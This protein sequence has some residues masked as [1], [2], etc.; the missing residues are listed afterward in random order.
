MVSEQG[1]PP[2]RLRERLQAVEP[3]LY[4]KGVRGTTPN[5]YDAIG[6]YLSLA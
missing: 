1:Q 3:G 2:A 6:R 5:L 4:F